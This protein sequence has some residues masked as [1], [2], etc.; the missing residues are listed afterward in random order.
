M[1]IFIKTL[2]GE[3]ITMNV[4]DGDTLEIAKIEQVVAGDA[5]DSEEDSTPDP[6]HN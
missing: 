2:S 3:T 5:P 6:L 4:E 1:Q